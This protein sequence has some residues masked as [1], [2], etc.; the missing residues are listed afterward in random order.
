MDMAMPKPMKI[1]A[2]R[3]KDRKLGVLRSAIKKGRV[4]KLSSSIKDFLAT[5]PTWDATL[6]DMSKAFPN[7]TCGLRDKIM[8]QISCINGHAIY[9]FF[10]IE[11][12]SSF[13]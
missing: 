9:S 4:R 12:S 1:K 11:S 2:D 5:V 3:A 8:V 13:A 10:R 7:R 6:V